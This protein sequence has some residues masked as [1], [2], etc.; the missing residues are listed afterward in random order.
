MKISKDLSIF[1][2]TITALTLSAAFL[3]GT[4]N[5]YSYSNEQGST[6]GMPFKSLQEQI[7]LLEIELQEAVNILQSQIDEIVIEQGE[8]NVLITNLQ[9]AVSTLEARV[10]QNEMDIDVLQAVQGFQQQ[11]IEALE[12]SVTDLEARVT[13]NEDDIEALVQVDQDL[14][15]LIMAIQAQIVTIN[16]R[17]TANDGDI[18]VLQAQVTS[19]QAQLSSVQVQL[20]SKQNRVNGICPAGSSIR[21]INSNGSVV[22]ETDNVSAGVGFL[23]TYRSFDQVNIASSVIFTRT[24]TNNRACTGSNYRAVG[25]GYDVNGHL[26]VGNVFENFAT[27]NTNWKVTVRS[28]ST[29]SRTLR[30]YVICARVQ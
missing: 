7:D 1:P 27:S 21:I 19:L 22:C 16:N 9:S 28:D 24:V 10:T 11:L 13:A 4:N 30:T 18:A 2:K 20:A 14:Q 29:G 15:Q 26:G 12:A 17:I 25:G 5:V 6:N 3:L 23:N 8:Q